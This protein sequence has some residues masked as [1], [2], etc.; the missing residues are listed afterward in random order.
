M[1]KIHVS[2][3]RRAVTYH[4]V[5]TSTRFRVREVFATPHRQHADRRGQPF[6]LLR[7][8]TQP[9]ETHD[10]EVLP[11]YAIRFEDG[12]EID[13][14]PDE[15]LHIDDP[16]PALAYVGSTEHVAF[17]NAVNALVVLVERALR[18]LV[19]DADDANSKIWAA[20][21]EFVRA[22][23]GRAEGSDFEDANRVDRRVI[24]IV[25]RWG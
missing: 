12:A 21:G 2:S 7:A 10:P 1:Q 14:W 5:V 9:D 23:G 16:K 13:A 8:I 17:W 4:D 6:E 15:V 3:D 24:Q 20:I 18:D 19:S 22:S 11:M 25:R